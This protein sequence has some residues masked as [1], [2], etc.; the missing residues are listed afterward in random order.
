EEETKRQALNVYRMKL[1]GAEVVPVTSGT[2][3][4]K[5]AGSVE[6]DLIESKGFKGKNAQAI[7]DQM[8][9]ENKILVEPIKHEELYCI[10]FYVAVDDA[11]NG[12]GER[13]EK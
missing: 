4:L 8:I 2:A 6:I 13:P 11:L 3:T 9:K 5:D 12:S 10:V 7:L 1:L